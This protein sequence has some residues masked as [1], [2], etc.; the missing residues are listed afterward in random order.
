MNR[1]SIIAAFFALLFLAGQNALAQSG[2]DLFQKGLV[3]ER[4]KGDLDEAI[5]IYERILKEFP[6]DRPVAAKAQ[7]HIGLCYEKLGLKEAQKAYQKVVDSYP[8]QAEAVKLANEKLSL[9]LRAEAVIR[10][11][12]KEFNI[13]KVWAGPH[14]DFHGAPSPDGRFLSYV[15]WEAGDSGN[16][17]LAIYELA[18]G[19]KRRLTDNASW[20][21]S[22]EYKFAL[23]S[24]WSPDGKQ[25]A[26]Q[27]SLK[28]GHELCVIGLDG[29]KPRILYSAEGNEWLS[30]YDWT[31]DGRQILAC[32]TGKDEKNKIVL[33][34]VADGSVRVLKTLDK[35]YGNRHSS[36]YAPEGM[37]FSPDGRYIVYDY[38]QKEDSHDIS[39]I[40]T[41]G[42]REIPL[43]EHPANDH[44]LG[45]APDGRNILFA[46]DR[47]GNHDT[48]V[49]RV[50]DGKPQGTP[51]LV[52]PD[53]ERAMGFTRDGSFYYGSGGDK[54]RDV[55]IAK[56]DP[57]TGEILVPPY[58]AINR[59]IGS[60]SLPDYSPDGKYLA[61]ISKR[62]PLKMHTSLPIGNVLCIRSL[63]TGEER[64]FRPEINSF[65]FPLWSPD[66]RSIMV[67]NWEDDDK[68]MVFYRIGAQTGEVKLVV[69]S[70]VHGIRAHEW[71]ADGKSI[72]LVRSNRDKGFCQIV[73]RDI[74]S[75][76][77]TE[78][79]RGGQSDMFT[80][81]ASPDGQ[82]LAFLNWTRETR[83]M[84]LRVIPATGGEPREIHRFD[85]E[86]YVFTI[87]TWT[88]D[89]KYI[90]MPKF[91][92]P[93][94]DG[95]WDLW[96]I[97]V[98]DGEP[99]NFGFEMASIWQLS[100]HPDG[101]HIAFC[102]TTSRPT[103]VWVMENFLPK[104]TA[105]E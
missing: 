96:R 35:Y 26:Y 92:P 93:K 62:P 81:S 30:P 89:G 12:D 11:E 33:V 31:P 13:R 79:Y 55:Y 54:I 68:H 29:S 60:N 65:G 83:E 49:I 2:Y 43:V 98:E 15:D 42:S 78:L 56:L 1:L 18:T 51:E 100:A 16:N 88:A 84:I 3:Q 85:Q 101:R 23:S 36:W 32:V 27:W 77:E 4:V 7:L 104:S 94:A 17:D 61:Y 14:V 82:W 40:S 9:L 25:I 70:E 44:V 74:E 95:K 73:V 6:K 37:S 86:N 102:T 91:R 45:W 38:P 80:I 105:G 8:E 34:S 24:V 75:G 5:K 21:E 66:S 39:L 103:E 52:K 53:I 97:P 20:Y 28:V 50:T 46:S 59:F 76:A 63:E 90:L 47:T 22:D 58:E 48:W 10:E 69:M 67:V 71:C 99:Q 72:F 57:E 64:A 41:D 87:H 19:K